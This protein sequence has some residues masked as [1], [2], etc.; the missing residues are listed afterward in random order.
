MNSAPAW[1]FEQ[2]PPLESISTDSFWILSNSRMTSTPYLTSWSQDPNLSFNTKK[3]IH[4]SFNTKFPTSY[5]ID[6]SL[7]ISSNT[8]R[9]LGI[10]LF[11]DLSWR[12]HYHH[13]LSKAYRTLGLLRHTFSH[14]INTTT[15]RTLYI[16]LVRSQLLYCSPLWHPYLI[17]DISAL[18]R[19]YIVPSYQI[20]TSSMIM[21]LIIKLALSNSTYYH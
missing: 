18:E 7:I 17:Q 20:A 6:D 11:T 8:H 3:L 19:I 15:K 16:A 4:L 2:V 13:I 5:N 14:A 21:F 12:N 10:I 9:D 1:S